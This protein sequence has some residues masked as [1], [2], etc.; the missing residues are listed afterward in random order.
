MNQETVGDTINNGT[1]PITSNSSL[2]LLC[3]I[4]K[5]WLLLAVIGMVS[6]VI[7]VVYAVF[8]KPNYESRL[9]FSLDTGSNDGSLSS[10]MNLAAQFG[11]GL[12]SGQSM[13]DGDNIIEI[14]QSRRMIESV[15]L[16]RE[17][18]DNKECTLADYYFEHSGIK[19]R[20]ASLQ[21]TNRIDFPIGKTKESLSY[22]QDSVLYVLYEHFIKENLYITRPDKKLSIY[23]LKITSNNEKFSKVFTDRLIEYTTNFY[24]EITSKKDKQTIEVLEQRVDQIKNNVGTSIDSRATSIDANTNL[25]YARPQTFATKQQYNIQAYSEAY[26]ELFKTLEMARYQYLKKKPLLQIIDAADYPMKKIKTSKLKS[27]ITF[28]I[29]AELL[30][31]LLL[32]FFL[33]K[34]TAFEK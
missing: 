6:S 30:T 12:G 14:M 3:I 8:Q 11:L 22:I 18:I 34:R 21:K 9:T 4:R 27:L 28:F 24:T 15:L 1:K 20:L 23:E 16:T 29:L 5:K 10:A 19:N 26:K 31:I 33:N 13:F 32:L 7:G 17:K 2:S 25:A